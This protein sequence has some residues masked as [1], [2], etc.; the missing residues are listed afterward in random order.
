M[1]PQWQRRYNLPPWEIES[2]RSRLRGGAYLGHDPADRLQQRLDVERTGFLTFDQLRRVVRLKLRVKVSDVSNED[3]SNLSYML[4]FDDCG[5][6]RV[7]DFVAF[8]LAEKQALWRPVTDGKLTKSRSL[9]SLSTTA[10]TP[11]QTTERL[12]LPRGRSVGRLPASDS[13]FAFGTLRPEQLTHA[14]SH[15]RSA[16]PSLRERLN[17]PLGPGAQELP[18]EEDVLRCCSSG[19]LGR[20]RALL[21]SKGLKPLSPE[22]GC[23]CVHVAVHF[24]HEEIA[25]L[26]LRAHVDPRCR[27]QSGSTLLM[28]AALYGHRGI[29]KN[30]LANWRANPMDVDEKGRNALHL[31]CCIDL[32]TLQMLAEH[33]PM[34]I[35]AKDA[36]GRGCFY[37][38]LANRSPDEQFRI[39]QYLLYKRCDPN[40]PD[41]DARS[42]LWYALEAGNYE[43]VSLLLCAGADV[44]MSL[45]TM[46]SSSPGGQGLSTTMSTSRISFEAVARSPREV[47]QGA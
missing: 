8:V 10:P 35:H 38:A 33:S 28:R 37:Y 30:L 4:D 23:K 13:G 16:S 34:G 22:V 24:G 5:M 31:A 39:L 21:A 45:L 14:I 47:V 29:V 18:F 46:D 44:D 32:G 15:S 25:D 1:R 11:T 40:A 43:A 42:A 41:H 12:G 2:I 3:L 17:L 7:E 26:L 9:S 27:A 19:N 20:L 36:L 6:V